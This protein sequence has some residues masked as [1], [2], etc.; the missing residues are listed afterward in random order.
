[1]FVVKITSSI[2]IG[3]IVSTRYFVKVYRLLFFFSNRLD[4]DRVKFY[5]VVRWIYS[6]ASWSHTADV[7]WCCGQDAVFK[8]KCFCSWLHFTWCI[9]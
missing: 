2:C 3:G 5:S 1:L 6:H 9:L 8:S 7:R 4:S